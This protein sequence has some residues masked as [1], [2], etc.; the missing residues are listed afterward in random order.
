MP[1]I[2]SVADTEIKT[3]LWLPTGIWIF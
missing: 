3:L 1:E 2:Q